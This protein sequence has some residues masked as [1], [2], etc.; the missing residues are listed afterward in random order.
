MGTHW[1]TMV[2]YCFPGKDCGDKNG[3]ES[4]A[5]GPAIILK[6]IIMKSFVISDHQKAGQA[7]F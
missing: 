7:Q 2:S 1:M 6:Y 3:G 5:P 4:T